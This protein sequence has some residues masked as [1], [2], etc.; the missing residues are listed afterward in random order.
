MYEALSA[1]VVPR[2]SSLHKVLRDIGRAHRV[3]WW[4]TRP[5]RVDTD[6]CVV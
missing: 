5:V 2:L 3:R 6:W 4:S 1:A